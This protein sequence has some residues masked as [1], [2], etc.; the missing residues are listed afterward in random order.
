[1]LKYSVLLIFAILFVVAIVGWTL[2]YEAGS[3][4]L[5]KTRSGDVVDLVAAYNRMLWRGL[6]LILLAIVVVSIFISHEVAGPMIHLEKSMQTIAA[7]D[8]TGKVLLRRGDEFRE[9]ALAFNSMTDEVKKKMIRDREHLQR[10][11][12]KLEEMKAKIGQGVASQEEIDALVQELKEIGA[13][14]KL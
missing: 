6:P 11:I 10:I 2:Y 13:E 1:Q 8:F 4:I 5:D 12:F 14:F 3:I 7:G 9:I